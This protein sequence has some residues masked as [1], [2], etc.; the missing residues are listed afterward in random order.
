M[1]QEA[2]LQIVGHKQDVLVNKGKNSI[3]G[4]QNVEQENDVDLKEN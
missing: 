3:T 2:F 1:K 4:R